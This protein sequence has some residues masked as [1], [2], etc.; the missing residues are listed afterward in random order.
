MLPTE[1]TARRSTP[2]ELEAI[3]V[4][5]LTW[6]LVPFLFLLYIVAYLD[7][8]NLGFAALQ[9]QQQLGFNDAVYGFE[10]EALARLLA[11]LSPPD[12]LFAAGND[13]TDE[14]LFERIQIDAWTVHLGPGP[15]R[16]AFV[17]PDVESLRRVL[18][19]FANVTSPVT[20]EAQ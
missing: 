7:R 14:A 2:Q 16:A 4:R 19:M 18:E 13:R 6:R 8:I 15:T 5:T 10:G 11:S 20:Q 1:T 3:V 12:F 9:M 17:V